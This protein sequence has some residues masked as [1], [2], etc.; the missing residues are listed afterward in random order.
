MPVKLLNGVT[1]YNVTAHNLN[2]WCKDEKG[3]QCIIVVP[4]DAVVNAYYVNEKVFSGATYDLVTVQFKP[5]SECE[6]ILDKFYA[7]S[8]E[9]LVVGSNIAAQAYPGRVLAPVPCRKSDR[10]GTRLP[11]DQ[12]LVRPD[13]FTIFNKE[14]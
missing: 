6:E 9:A 11:N 2:F 1:I 12:R 10:S 14:I 13:R 8:P 3:K 7:E 4:S 5:L